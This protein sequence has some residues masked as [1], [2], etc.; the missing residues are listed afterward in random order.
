MAIVSDV[1]IRLRADIARLQQDLNA[2]RRSVSGAVDGMKKTLMGLAA[3]FSLANLAQQAIAAQ[4][5]F[6]KLNTSLV[7][8]TGSNKAA[9]E[10]FGVL[11]DFAA[12]TPFSVQEVTT[13]FLK[14]RNLGL[15]PSERALTSYGNTASGMGKDLN[16]LIEAVAD[17]ATGEFERLKEFGIKAKQ[18]GDQV[19]LTFQGTTTKVGNNAADIE[20]YLMKIGEVN[21]AGGMAR[22]ADTLDGAISNLGDAWDQTLIAFSQSGFGDAVRSGVMSLSGALGDLIAMFKSV[23][24][25]ADDEGKKVEEIGPLHKGLTTFFE[26][27]MVLG[28][29]V[30]Y[31]FKTIGKDIGT[32]AAQAAMLFNGGI[33]GLT[34]GSTLKAV[35]DLGRARVA[36]S[37]RER[38]EVDATSAKI[39]GAAKAAQAVREQDAANRAK[40]STDRLAKY[41][42][43]ADGAKALSDTERKELEKRAKAYKDFSAKIDESVMVTAREAAGLAPL[44]EGQKLDL[45]LK[46]KLT[47]GTLKLTAAQDASARARIKEVQ[48][49]IEANKD[50]EEYAKYI[51]DLVEQQKKL[52]GEREDAWL[53]AREEARA[54]EE[55]VT[56]FGMSKAALER[57]A[58]A[59]LQDQLAQKETLNLTH[60]EI[61][62]LQNLIVLKE[63]SAEAV[64]KLEELEKVQTFWTDIEKT[65]HDTFMS[66]ED[67]GKGMWQRMRESAKNIFFNWL[68]QMTVKKWIINIGASISGTGG[69]SGIAG[70]ADMM[71]GGSG[72]GGAGGIGSYLSMGQTIYKGF[73]SGFSSVGTGLGTYV[74][75]L[76]NTM[77]S[78]AV[79][80]FGSGMS[81]SSAQAAQAAA[82]YNSAGMTAT[83]SAISAGSA[84]GSVASVA[85]GAAIGH[86]GGRALS[87]GFSAVG[88]S[89][90]SLVNTGT[91]AGM[92]IG[93]YVGGPLGAAIGAALGGVIGGALNRAFGRKAREYEDP[94]VSGSL[95][96]S[97]VSGSMNSKWI[98]KGGWF[99]SDKRGT[100]TAAIDKEISD[101]LSGGYNAIKDVTVGFAEVFGQ[102]A[103]VV[104]GYSKELNFTVTKDAAKNEQMLTELFTSIGDD[105]AARVVPNIA[106]FQRSG[107][108]AAQTLERLAGEFRV[109]DGVLATFGATSA[110]AFRAVGTASIEARSRLVALAGGVDALAQQTQF[111][112]DNFLTK[113]QQ[114]APLQRELAA[115]LAALG[116]ANLET[117]DQFAKTVMG[118]VESGALAT[119]EGAKLYTE[120]MKLGPAFKAV[121][122]YAEEVRAAGRAQADMAMDEITRAV[123]VQ[124]SALMSVYDAVMG[125]LNAGIDSVNA[126]IERTGDLSRALKSAIGT[127]DSPAQQDGMRKAAQAQITASLAI[128]KAGGALP[129]A[130]DLRDALAALSR[131]ASGQF[132]T[133]ADY[134]REVARTNNELIQLGG[135]SD[136]QLSTA[137]RQLLVLQE[138][139]ALTKAAADVQTAR[140]DSLVTNGQFMVATLAANNATLNDIYGVVNSLRLQA[141]H[142]GHEPQRTLGVEMMRQ[143]DV[144]APNYTAP[145]ATINSDAAILAALQA[146]ES[147]MANVETN[148]Q[149]AAAASTQFA[150]QFDQV[151]A[152]GNALATETVK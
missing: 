46:Q 37:V 132:A 62:Q 143:L 113:A 31:V 117:K 110:Q 123:D 79:S 89:G 144:P 66:I 69:V 2:A 33:K 72:A 136:A 88:G 126:T 60:D 138:Q 142:L 9:A 50:R 93:M 44:N 21:F 137:E 63:R 147:R 32:F 18:Q 68:Y 148:T 100:D 51:D 96:D 129:T 8:V 36:E 128:A 85:A 124:K 26:T 54:N 61:A 115:G 65:A 6:D 24:G 127:V 108:S 102:S 134:Q 43:Q 90:N 5:Q 42:I 55:L 27:I 19:A 121:A 41:K 16:Q 97:G 71:G 141:A 149:R 83:G 53:A 35:Q 7:T 45:E 30:A 103:D 109:V 91:A 76:G 48:V 146:L 22:Q 140:L 40:D 12:K 10:A 49:N 131:D 38:A 111:F 120:L 13:A 112:A 87:N 39:L 92:G 3:G 107:E 17:A 119:E 139:A 152:G 20:A 14:L 70:A 133:L 28:V 151:S 73:A 80:A 11:Q 74:S 1:E 15:T 29:N 56:T 86:Y 82:A 81:M 47:E 122:D 59:R 106:Q 104:A 78:S 98:E 52:T 150:Q 4:R 94:V 105:L 84:A 95:G 58:L 23:T 101:I 77:G 67:G 135:M 34:D 64:A 99:R 114:V 57:H 145:S 116:Y 25:A 125:R 75:A 118:L 130:E